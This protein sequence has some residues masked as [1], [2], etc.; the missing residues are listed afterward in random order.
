MSKSETVKPLT[1]V[2]FSEA[3]I[4]LS[5]TFGIVPYEFSYLILALLLF[6]FL[7]FEILD[8]L[9]LFI[10]SIPFF[11]ALPPNQFSDS[12]NIWRILIIGLFLKLLYEKSSRK[13]IY[14]KLTEFR[15]TDYYR[16]SCTTALFLVISFLSLF[17][18]QDAAAGIKKI[19]FIINIFLLFPIVVFCIKNEDNLVKIMKF[20]LYSSVSVVF[21]G[22]L[23]FFSTFF[24]SLYDFW[25]F[26]ATNVIKALYGQGLSGLLS[27]SNTWFSYYEDLPPT[28]R[29][30]SVMPDS[31]S[32]AMFVII[33]IPVVFSLF[34][35]F[36][37]KKKKLLYLIMP[38]FLLSI[39]LSGSRGAWVGSVFAFAASICL[40]VP[41]KSKTIKRYFLASSIDLKNKINS[42]LI[43][44][45]VLLFFILIPVSS[46]VL[47][48]NQKVRLAY[49]ENAAAEEKKMEESAIFERVASISNL[50][51]ASNKGRL[52]IWNET[53]ISI[54]NHPFL[55]IGI[56]N[57]PVV[58]KENISNAKKGSSAHSV[59]FDIA[60]EIGIFGLLVF[61]FLVA[62]I[63][64]ISYI[65]FYE[66]EKKYL[67]MF[68]GSFFVYFVWIC[69]YSFFDTVVLNDK[70]L[71]LTVIMI[72]ILY[73]LRKVD[74][75]HTD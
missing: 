16:L 51:E 9:S 33:S 46:F 23:Q 10:I 14:K 20:I 21:I 24:V 29:M 56:G 43:I 6:S 18:A 41:Y 71:M 8:S 74:L 36:N 50:S 12:M 49:N 45:S 63:I 60:A 55:G 39:F 15:K 66:L 34:F 70:V 58:L 7:R 52:Q 65:L 26:W 19:A 27:Y 22:Y 48:Q 62:E 72:G 4:V 2:F 42:K 38:S 30:F 17:F 25:Q 28:L 68:A 57:F 75:L 54:I 1:T 44:Y 31:H 64:E 37:T 11:V 32:F 35:Y 73:S 3:I 13:A 47:A 69:S 67:K 53:I 59:Y 40:L 5:M 61:L